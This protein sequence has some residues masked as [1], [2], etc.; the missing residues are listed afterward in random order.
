MNFKEKE[1]MAM[2]KAQRRF[3]KLAIPIGLILI[4]IF[5]YIIYIP[6]MD[7]T[8][9]IQLSVL[10]V[11]I[12]GFIFVIYQIN[13]LREGISAQA[14]QNLLSNYYGN[15]GKNGLIDPLYR[16][17][18]FPDQKTRKDE[19]ITMFILTMCT[20]EAV[21]IQREEGII[22]DD[23]WLPWKEY[24]IKTIK[25]VSFYREMWKQIRDENIYHMG[26]KELIDNEIE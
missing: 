1:R 15:F 6:L 4:L 16:N 3:I 22:S 20:F 23:V 12:L 26:L 2:D 25:N 10:I 7:N 13:L 24:F 17:Y 9:K 18:Y 11:S 14:H 5:L 19:E 8:S 21:F